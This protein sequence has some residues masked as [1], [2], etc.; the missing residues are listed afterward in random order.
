VRTETSIGAGGSSISWAAVKKAEQALGTL[1][2]KSVLIIGAG[3][4][5]ELAADDLQRRGFF[6]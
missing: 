6:R 5:S 1:T 3:K 4:M 2:G